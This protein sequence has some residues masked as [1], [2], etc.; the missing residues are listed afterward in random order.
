[1]GRRFESYRERQMITLATILV[2]KTLILTV[3][4]GAGYFD[5]IEDK[6][7]LVPGIPS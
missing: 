2:I 3:L 7:G 4:A 1:M 6:S 5:P